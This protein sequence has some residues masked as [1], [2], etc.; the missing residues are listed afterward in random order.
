MSDDEHRRRLGNA[1]RF[2]EDCVRFLDETFDAGLDV[3]GTVRPVPTEPVPGFMPYAKGGVHAE[4]D[5]PLST[6]IGDRS[7]KAAAG[8]LPDSVRE[9]VLAHMDLT[10][11]H[12]L[13]VAVQGDPDASEAVGDW[14]WDASLP[15]D[16]LDRAGLS[17]LVTE[18]ES[19]AECDFECETLRFTVAAMDRHAMRGDGI[20]IVLIA[21]T[22]FEHHQSDGA[23]G[24][25][26]GPDP[27]RPRVDH[28]ILDVDV[29]A[30][31]DASPEKFSALL[32]V[33]RQAFPEREVVPGMSP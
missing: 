11:R 5:V 3:A 6:F 9:A 33:V 31:A 28:V 20:G 2:V 30:A 14:D 24:R 17:D 32:Q 23:L 27:S 16:R 19:T 12:H 15:F 8:S 10:Y 1:C 26:I 18:A 29:S 7:L 4:V 21:N 25:N 22:E 13:E